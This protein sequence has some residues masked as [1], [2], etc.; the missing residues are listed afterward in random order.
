MMQCFQ[1]F[2]NVGCTMFLF[3]SLLACSDK[4]D[5]DNDGYDFVGMDFVLESTEGYELVVEEA[6]T[7]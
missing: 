7:F 4:S 1:Y 3:I 5:P 2:I 6:R